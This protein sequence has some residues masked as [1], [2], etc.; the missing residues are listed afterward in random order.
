MN[1][2]NKKYILKKFCDNPEYLINFQY[3]A[4]RL[5]FKYFIN[6]VGKSCDS[7]NKGPE[8]DQQEQRY[9]VKCEGDKTYLMR[10]NYETREWKLED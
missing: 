6:D 3:E 1:N 10:F 5:G 9:I 8:F 2:L 7:I 4:E